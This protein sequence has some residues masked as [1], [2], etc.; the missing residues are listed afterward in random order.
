MS[1][2]VGPGRG[3]MAG[4]AWLASVGPAPV[5][6]WGAAMGWTRSVTFSHA[7][8]LTASGLA[9]RCATRRGAGSLLYA[10]RAGVEAAEVLAAPVR[11][12][13][14]RRRGSTWRRARGRP[15]G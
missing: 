14:R 12:S 9:A 2:A 6:A 3:S 7:A 5:R 13:R 11:A 15:H 4:L 10:T 1:R 8:R